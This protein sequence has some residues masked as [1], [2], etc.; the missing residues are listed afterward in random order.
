MEILTEV[1]LALVGF[2]LGFLSARVLLGGLL[3]VTFGKRHP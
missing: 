1:G 2:G 3:S